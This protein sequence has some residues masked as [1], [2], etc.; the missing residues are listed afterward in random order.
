VKKTSWVVL[1][2]LAI[3]MSLPTVG[4]AA[5]AVNGKKLHDASC[6]TECHAKRVNGE[7]NK[8]YTRDN[9]KKSL[10]ALKA[11]VAICNEKVLSSKWFPEDE[12]DVVEYLNKEF[13]HFK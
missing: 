12:A 3:A 11:Q 5:D 2:G 6:V 7:S 9:N 10:E 4:Q 1:G 8:L 13:Y